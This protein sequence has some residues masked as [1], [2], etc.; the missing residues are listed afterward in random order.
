YT[1]IAGYAR[2]TLWVSCPDH[3]DMDLFAKLR[4]L[5][6]QG[7]LVEQFNIP[8]EALQGCKSKDEV[9]NTNVYRHLGPSARLRVS[10][11]H[12]IRPVQDGDEVDSL[13]SHQK[14]EKIHPIGSI[15]KV[16]MGFWPCGM[17]FERGEA[18]QLVFAGHEMT[19][20][21]TDQLSGE[22]V[23]INHGR[24]FIHTGDQ[25][26]SSLVLPFIS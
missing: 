22:D 10:H 19:L 26:P 21:E 23:T 17:L 9:P 1:E 2:M 15:V 18:L 6:A 12:L 13:L 20:P 7:N 16:E 14:E 5:D 11:R 3:D 24:H 25:Y 4:K 8:L